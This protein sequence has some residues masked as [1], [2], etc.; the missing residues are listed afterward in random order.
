VTEGEK[1]Y[2]TAASFRRGVG[3]RLKQAAN[4]RGR[5]VLEVRREFLFQRFLARVFADPASRWVLKGGTGLLVRLPG[6][7]HSRDIDLLYPDESLDLRRAVEELRVMARID[8]ADH[9]SF[10]VDDPVLLGD[11]QTLATIGVTGYTGATRFDRFTIDLSTEVHVV[12][13][14]ERL[15]PEPVIDVP[16]L[17]A[18]PEFTLYPLPDQVADKVCAMY[19]S[20]GTPPGPSTRFRDLIDLALIVTTSPLDAELTSRALESEA[21][22]RNLTL[23]KRMHAPGS[24]WRAGYAETA[25]RSGLPAELHNLEAALA[26]VAECLNPLLAGTLVSGKWDAPQ[27]CWKGA[28]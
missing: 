14:F 23:P 13:R 22:R 4:A 24:A 16:G 18:L 20:Y 9:L 21:R 17:P 7:R 5:P 15:R 28:T 11:G 8:T 27:R 1:G 19:A 3:D 2:L 10:V 26:R 25:R 12:A 6:A